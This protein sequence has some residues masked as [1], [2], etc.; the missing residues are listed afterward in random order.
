M[1]PAA[2][3]PHPD[4]SD[5]DAFAAGFPHGFFRYLRA[6]Q[7]V[8]WHARNRQGPDGF[9]V[10]SRHQDIKHV[11]QRPE[12]FSS[13][14]G[15]TI[16]EASVPDDVEYGQSSII[17]MDP[18]E[19]IR[20][21]K[22]VSGAF[23]PARLAA[24][25]SHIEQLA[26]RIVDAAA[27]KGAGDFVLDVAAEL[28][29]RVIS[30]F[31]G[32]PGAQR[33]RLFD[34][35]NKML[36][37]EDP[38]FNTSEDSMQEAAVDLYML[39]GELVQA[40]KKRLRGDIISQLMRAE[41]DGERLTEHEFNGFFVILVNAGNETTRNQTAQGLRL[42][43]EHPEQ[44]RRLLDDPGL[45]DGAVE[46]MLRFNPPVMYFRRTATRDLE[47]GGTPIKKG[48]S[49]AIYYP[50]A[51]RDERV[52]DDPDRFDI[53]REPNPHLAFGIGEHFCLGAR[54]ARIQLRAV[55]RALLRLAPDIALDG[56]IQFLRSHFIDGIKRMPVRFAPRAARAVER[57]RA[58]G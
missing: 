3:F 41:I 21:R 38:E 24:L 58:T 15:I 45:L 52:F 12:L 20:Y 56:D 39:S 55:F 49:V 10:V 13:S 25:E 9:F 47:L 11:S 8:Y 51:N 36:G 40:R 42:L 19:H 2:P 30:E 37:A 22:L 23:K 16:A 35:S 50:S 18:P 6:E 33:R 54:L 57:L 46:E 43:L 26:E 44:K 14:E 27:R 29:L 48:Q 1:S 4:L 5:P 28:P 31:I 34:A 53:G 17:F 7:P 32:V